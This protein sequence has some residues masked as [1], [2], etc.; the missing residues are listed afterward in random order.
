V[1]NYRDEHMYKAAPKNKAT[2]EFGSAN[3]SGEF[4]HKVKAGESLDVISKKYGVSINDLKR[5]NG[6]TSHIIRI[7]QHPILFG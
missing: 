7:G 4:Q 6:L 1:L 3:L 2:P 5:W